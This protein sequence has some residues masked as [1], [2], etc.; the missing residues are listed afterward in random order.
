RAYV[1]APNDVRDAVSKELKAALVRA[2]RGEEAVLREIADEGLTAEGR[3]ER[4]QELA[5]IRDERGDASGATD[6]LLQA[7]SE[8]PTAALW[9]AVEASAEKS[10]R[11][12]IRVEA[13]QKLV[14]LA[15]PAERLAI[16]KRLARAEAGR[17]S[18]AAAET[19]WR[20]VWAADP[21]D[22]EADVAI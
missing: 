21:S 2:G 14:E 10:G 18:L 5:K 3:A 17:G 8:H 4:W 16:M 6:A 19:A 12:H 13:L 20:A 7:A 22:D 11:E 1:I 9:A 15:T